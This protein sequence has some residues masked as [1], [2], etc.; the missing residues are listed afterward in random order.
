MNLIRNLL[1]LLIVILMLPVCIETF[2]YVTNYECDYDIVNDEIA[3]SQLREQMLFTYDMYVSSDELNFIYKGKQY[4][5]SYVN[6]KMIL[7][8]GTQIYIN[9]IDNL[10]FEEKDG[11][12]YV[13]YERNN[14]QYER[15]ISK[16]TGLYIDDFS[17][18]DVIDDESNCD[19]E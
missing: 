16:K 5:L 2:V 8:P 1:G 11:C 19:E 13:I 9:N 18:C 7:Q 17:Y 14:K 3:L 12:I 4:Q 6:G 10:T 15:I